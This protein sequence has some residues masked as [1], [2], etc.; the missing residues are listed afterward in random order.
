MTGDI[1]VNGVAMSNMFFL[2][3]AAY[4][5][6]EDRLW[7][8]LTGDDRQNVQGALRRVGFP[9]EH[10]PVFRPLYFEL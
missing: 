1:T 6:Q 10:V 4:V 8:A 2:E 3:N 7:S 9:Q 5:P